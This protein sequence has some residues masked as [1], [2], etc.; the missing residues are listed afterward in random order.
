[1]FDLVTIQLICQE[2]WPT[3]WYICISLSHVCRL[4]KLL[5]IIYVFNHEIGLMNLNCYLL[6][7]W[8]NDELTRNFA[9]QVGN[10]WEGEESGMFMSESDLRRWNLK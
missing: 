7:G 4:K 10:L 2:T 8:F 9:L 5:C 1:M 6:V 3:G